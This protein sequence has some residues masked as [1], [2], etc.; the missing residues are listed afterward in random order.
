[1]K[2]VGMRDAGHELDIQL[3]DAD[4]LHEQREEILA[5]HAEVNAERLDDPF[6]SSARYWQRVEAYATRDGFAM[7]SARLGNELIGFALGYTLPANSLWW[8][9]FRGNVDPALLTETGRRTFALNELM[10]RP[11]WRRRGYARALHDALLQDRSEARVTLLVRP[12]N[13]PAHAAYQSWGWY[14]LGELQPFDDS[15]VFDVMMRD[16]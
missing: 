16:L 3:H 2:D 13:A 6:Y 8:R 1:M 12:D 9:G 11:A 10:V 14:K 4:G 15:P 5:V 7:A